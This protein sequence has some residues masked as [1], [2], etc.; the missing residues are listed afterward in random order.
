MEEQNIVNTIY[1]G[2]GFTIISFNPGGSNLFRKEQDE[3][4]EVL[5]FDTRF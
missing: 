4:A 2:Y 5:E 1:E 3:V